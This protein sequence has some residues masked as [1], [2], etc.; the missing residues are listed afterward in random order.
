MIKLIIIALALPL[1]IIVYTSMCY[2]AQKVEWSQKTAISSV[3]YGYYGNT[4]V[5]IKVDT[6]GTI[7]LH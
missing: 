5:P 6:D 1:M 7:Y 2:S 3:A 4:L